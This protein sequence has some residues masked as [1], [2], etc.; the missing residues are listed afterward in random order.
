[1]F[2]SHVGI[3]LLGGS[4]G[5]IIVL[6]SQRQAERTHPIIAVDKPSDTAAN[7]VEDADWHGCGEAW[8]RCHCSDKAALCMP[9]NA[10]ADQAQPFAAI[11]QKVEG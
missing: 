3:R 8:R 2:H 5:N 10:A 7:L 9:S 11:L 4:R 6:W 1:V